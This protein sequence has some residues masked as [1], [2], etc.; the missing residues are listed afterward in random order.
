MLRYS[1]LYYNIKRACK[2]NVE[3]NI[4]NRL[5]KPPSVAMARDTPEM[6]YYTVKCCY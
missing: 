6:Y 2:D 4:R 3:A 5:C 1:T